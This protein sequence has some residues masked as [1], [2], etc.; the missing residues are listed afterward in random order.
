[1]KGS[2]FKFLFLNLLKIILRGKDYMNIDKVKWFVKEKLLEKCYNY[3]LRVVEIVIKL[4]EI[5]DGDISKVELVGVLYDFC[6]Y[7]D[8]GKMY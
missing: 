8:L 7:D 1:M 4:V 5:Y 3:F 6:K 2:L